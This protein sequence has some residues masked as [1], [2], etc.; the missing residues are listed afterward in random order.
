MKENTL[1]SILHPEF[2]PAEH[3]SWS[4]KQGGNLN[5]RTQIFTH[6]S[7]QTNQAK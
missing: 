4:V 3:Q 2:W 5:Q 7:K 6:R 1:E